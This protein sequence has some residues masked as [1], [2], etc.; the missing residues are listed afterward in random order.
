M[1]NIKMEDIRPNI[2][3][4]LPDDQVQMETWHPDW[5][6]SMVLAQMR[7]ES[8]TAEGTFQAAIRVLDHYSAKI[9]Q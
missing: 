7:V 5:V 9:Q 8:A 4:Y 6:K 3:K 1:K 2:P